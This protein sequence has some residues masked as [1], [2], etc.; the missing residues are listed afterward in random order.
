MQRPARQWITTF[1]N[2]SL[3][4]PSRWACLLAKPFVALLNLPVRSE[5]QGALLILL[6]SFVRCQLTN[7]KSDGTCGRIKRLVGALHQGKICPWTSVPFDISFAQILLEQNWA[8]T[9]PRP[10]GGRPKTWPQSPKARACLIWLL[11]AVLKYANH[12]RY[13]NADISNKTARES[14]YVRRTQSGTK[15]KRVLKPALAST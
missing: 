11:F 3:S 14:G 8:Q 9:G 15:A 4:A 10:K 13:L 12:I 1:L 5:H 2:T 7:L 6:H